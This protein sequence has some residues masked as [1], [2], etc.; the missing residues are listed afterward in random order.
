MK[1]QPLACVSFKPYL[2]W[3]VWPDN[4]WQTFLFQIVHLKNSRD[5]NFTDRVTILPIVYLK[6]RRVHM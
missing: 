6:R 1:I 5:N 2:S 3:F 4:Y